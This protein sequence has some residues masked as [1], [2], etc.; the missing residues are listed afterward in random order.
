M[1]PTLKE[2]VKTLW[3][4]R[5]TDMNAVAGIFT[6]YIHLAILFEYTG[7]YLIRVQSSPYQKKKEVCRHWRMKTC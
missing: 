7:P 3:V 5:L 2:T 6:L 1:L 4:N